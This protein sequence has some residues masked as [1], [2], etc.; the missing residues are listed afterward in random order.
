MISTTYVINYS[1]SFVHLLAIRYKFLSNLFFCRLQRWKFILNYILWHFLTFRNSY[2]TNSAN[3]VKFVEV[4]HLSLICCDVWCWEKTTLSVVTLSSQQG[5]SFF[6]YLV[7]GDGILSLVSIYLHMGPHILVILITV[8]KLLW[9]GNTAAK[10][11][12]ICHYPCHA[13]SS[14]ARTK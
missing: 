11:D 6:L 9:V 14:R 3:S 10:F 2:A 7:F 4:W 1:H 5:W 13:H 12:S 8:L